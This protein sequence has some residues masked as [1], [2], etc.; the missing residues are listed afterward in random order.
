MKKLLIPI[1]LGC[2]SLFSACN[3]RNEDVV[4]QVPKDGS[5]EVTISTTELGNS[6]LY[7]TNSKVYVKGALV[8]T[9]V[10]TDTI[11]GLGTTKDVGVDQD[12]N[13]KEIQVPKFYET[14]IT[15]K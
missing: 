7:T 4:N 8:K 12:G 3:E 9:I 14:F 5:I 6:I 2:L 13:E 10:K 15:V 1:L 11:P